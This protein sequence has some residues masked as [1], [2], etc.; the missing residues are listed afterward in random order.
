[1]IRVV[2][3]D[4]EALMRSGLSV[5][6][7]SEEG[8]EVVGEASD[9][10]AAVELV[11]RERPDVVCM[12]IRMP[13]LD[14]LDATR[15]ISE[16]PSL[17]GCRVL[18][19]TTFDE[20]AYVFE[21]L[22]HGACGFLLKDTPPAELISAIRVIAEGDALL[23]PS[24]TRRLIAEFARRPEPAAPA[25]A[26]LDGL[27]SREREVLIAIGHGWS[28]AEIANRLF[29]S[30]ATAKTHVSRL[31]T[32]LAARDRAQLVILAFETGLVQVNH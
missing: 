24:V 11:R 26:A 6:L 8:I 7:T 28:N 17:S 3:A 1:M 14:G 21:A 15:R 22:R 4:D 12:D 31:L 2:I 16:D 20:D 18:I 25:P 30:Y 32:K 13:V 9:G 10:A 23:A 29:M 5:L 27:T 19:I